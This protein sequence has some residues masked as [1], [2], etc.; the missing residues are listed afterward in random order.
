MIIFGQLEEFFSVF[1]V[2]F[3]YS[4]TKMFIQAIF[5][6]ASQHRLINKF[7]SGALDVI[8]VLCLIFVW[9]NR[10]M[11][12][13]VKS[14][15]PLNFFSNLIWFDFREKQNNKKINIYIFSLFVTHHW[16]WQY[17]FTQTYNNT[18]IFEYNLC[19]FFSFISAKQISNVM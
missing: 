12:M 16:Q 13:M 2:L 19:V 9:S 1:F 7:I 14:E 11:M 18:D 8:V 4:K 3:L 17:V 10:M 5:I 15:F 6:L